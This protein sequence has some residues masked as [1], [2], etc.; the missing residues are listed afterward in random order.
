TDF[1]RE[2]LPRSK[3]K[4]DKDLVQIISMMKGVT[5]AL[6]SLSG[7]D[8]THWDAVGEVGRQIDDF[9]L[10]RLTGSR[11]TSDHS[12]QRDDSTMM[13]LREVLPLAAL[14][15]DRFKRTKRIAD[16]SAGFPPVFSAPVQTMRQ[17]LA[18]AAGP[19]ARFM[20]TLLL[21]DQQFQKRRFQLNAIQF[22]DIEHGALALLDQEEIRADY[23]EKYQEIYIDE[24]QDTSSIQDALVRRISD[25]NLLMVGDIKQS[26]YRFRYAN[27]SLFA[28][29]E[30]NSC[31]VFA[32]QTPP[33]LGPQESG[34]LAL[35]NRCFRTRPTIIDFINDFFQ[36]FL[37]RESGEI[38]YDESQKLM[39]DQDKWQAYDSQDQGQWPTGVFLDLA[40]SLKGSPDTEGEEGEEKD[41]DQAPLDSLLPADLTLTA[42]GQEALMAA[43]I[44]RDLVERGVGYDQIAILLPTNNHCRVYEES[45]ALCGIPVTSR[46]GRF[47]PDSLVFRQVE[48][49]LSVLDNPRQ[50]IPLLSFMMGPFASD[51]W[52]GEELLTLANLEDGSLEASPGKSAKRRLTFHD[53]FF[54]LAR[55]TD[56]ALSPKARDL[57]ARIDRWR[58]LAQELDSS[59]LLDLVF[60][61]CNYHD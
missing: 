55:T 53:K 61:E 21:V 15:S 57:A 30:A 8:P 43:R 46:S 23:L 29:Y 52:T 17:A 13:I 33:P 22:S 32:G 5:H 11:S 4:S 51:P 59:D 39:A 3:T 50:D 38:D 58:F 28:G 44:I 25:S 6:L 2:D 56:Q 47:F 37:T 12:R 26:I 19:A 14:I 24:Y 16:A 41:P 34:Y 10:P 42:T 20:E 49:L 18:R 7:H 45:L 54:S 48:A 40:T 27:P 31:L 35:L 1:W 36:S 9:P 60:S